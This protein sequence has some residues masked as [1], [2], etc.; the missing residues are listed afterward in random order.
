MPPITIG[1]LVPPRTH[2]QRWCNNGMVVPYTLEGRMRTLLNHVLKWHP[3]CLFRSPGRVFS[4]PATG[5]AG[6]RNRWR[7]VG[8]TSPMTTH[9]AIVMKMTVPGHATA[10]EFYS[11]VRVSLAGGGSPVDVF[12]HYGNT[13]SSATGNEPSSWASTIQLLPVSPDTEYEFRWA[14][15]DGARLVSGLIFEMTAAANTTLG[16]LFPGVGVLTPIYDSHRDTP[17][18]LAADAWRQQGGTCINFTTDTDAGVRTR[19]SA[20]DI[21]LV[22]NSSTA[23]SVNTPG[24]KVDNVARC[25]SSKSTV[26]Y[27]F[28]AFGAMPAGTG[29]VYLKDSTGAV[30]ATININAA[31]Q[32]WYSTTVNLPNTE[33]KYDVHYDGDGV[34]TVSVYAVQLYEYST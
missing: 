17:H 27:V 4:I 13:T 10:G 11:S 7:G 15:H 1:K 18:E 21:N 32:A 12:M 29:H 20:T 3:K 8:R 33:A 19:S 24:I 16:Y 6:T 28:K 31:A 34:N 25:R 26:P 5:G 9:L 2:P 14:D 22:D 30:L 23:V